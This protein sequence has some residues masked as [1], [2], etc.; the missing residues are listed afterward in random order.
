MS[1]ERALRHEKS[2]K[3]SKELKERASTWAGWVV[4]LDPQ[5]AG[6]VSLTNADQNNGW[7][8]CDRLSQLVPFWQR[9]II[10]ADKGE[11]GERWEKFYERYGDYEYDPW[12]GFGDNHVDD[13][14]GNNGGNGNNDDNNGWGVLDVA[15]DGWGAPGL[16]DNGWGVPE[17]DDWNVPA[18]RDWDLSLQD[19]WAH[20]G[21]K[22]SQALYGWDHPR[23][24][25]TSPAWM[26]TQDS[27]QDVWHEATYRKKKYWV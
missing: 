19:T 5:Q 14:W 3:H 7:G 4:H 22:A 11:K 13:P 8:Y 12:F 10:A 16:Q 6:D 1:T 26:N 17:A 27:S 2:G 20:E 18:A 15:G 9:G 23:Q 21:V 25:G 24:D